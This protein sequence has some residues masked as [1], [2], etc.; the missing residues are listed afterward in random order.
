MAEPTIQDV[1][2]IIK[3]ETA[4]REKK[5]KN[6]ELKRKTDEKKQDRK[7]EQE[8]DKINKLNDQYKNSLDQISKNQ[9]LEESYFLRFSSLILIDATI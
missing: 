6:D 3:A 4:E 7:F 2:N 5:A 8:L 9:I 1:M